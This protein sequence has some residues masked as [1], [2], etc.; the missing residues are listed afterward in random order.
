MSTPVTVNDLTPISGSVQT[1]RISYAV[2]P[3]GKNYGQNYG[4]KNWYSDIPNDGKCYV[5]DE[6]IINWVEVPCM[7]TGSIE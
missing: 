7:P 6:S 5:W 4:G 3:A 2:E 1:S